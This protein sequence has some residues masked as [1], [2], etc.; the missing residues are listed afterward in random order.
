MNYTLRWDPDAGDRGSWLRKSRYGWKRIWGGVVVQN[1]CEAIARLDL[2]QGMLRLQKLGLQPVGTVHDEVWYL[3]P[4]SEAEARHRVVI[5][6]LSR[7]PA[8]LPQLP[9]AVEGHM[10]E[11]Y[12][13]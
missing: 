6:E 9:V 3:H 7:S 1:I 2:S 11:R 8:W 5:E 4:K 12:E 10:G 13:K